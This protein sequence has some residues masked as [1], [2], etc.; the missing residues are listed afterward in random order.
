MEYELMIPP[1]RHNGFKELSKKQA[2]EY[3]DW[4]TN[5]INH[6]IEVISN[7]IS[8]TGEKIH[9]DYSP[10]SLIPIWSWYEKNIIVEDK[11]KEEL[12]NEISKHPAWMKN[13]ISSTKIS[14]ETF[15]FGMDIAIYFAEIII[16]NSNGKVYWGYFTKP[17]NRMS[18]N[19]PV[20]LGFKADMDLNPR[21]VITN[22]TRRSYRES[23]PDRLHEMY[24]N[25]M[26]FIEL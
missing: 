23:Q 15:K 14:L 12:E 24:K 13:E 16:R 18:V 4:Y 26:Q 11:T 7:Y 2:E 6:R 22:C 19:Q 3:F 8:S 1:F 20:L 10:D 25:W 21:L 9:F 17:K 5:Q